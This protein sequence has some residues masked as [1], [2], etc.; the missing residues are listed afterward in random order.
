MQNSSGFGLA[1]KSRVGP[2]GSALEHSQ[3]TTMMTEQPMTVALIDLAVIV[4][5][6]RT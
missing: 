6:N 3:A 4:A 2:G 5:A 1:R